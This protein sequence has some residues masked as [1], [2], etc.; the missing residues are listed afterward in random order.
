VAATKCPAVETRCPLA[1]TACPPSATKCPVVETQCPH[2]KPTPG[3]VYTWTGGSAQTATETVLHKGTYRHNIAGSL[4][5]VLAGS[6]SLADPF[7][8]AFEFQ[9]TDV[10]ILVAGPDYMDDTINDSIDL[11]PTPIDSNLRQILAAASTLSE[12]GWTVNLSFNGWV[13]IDESTITGT[14]RVV[15]PEA[16]VSLPIGAV[17]R[18]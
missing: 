7:T 18:R 16:G 8:G 6:G 9:G 13:S 3:G 5:I 12:G 1:V 15:I 11:A 17:L 4:T 2:P 10:A 14:I